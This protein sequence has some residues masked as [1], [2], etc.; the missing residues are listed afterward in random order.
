M[1][2]MTKTVSFLIFSLMVCSCNFINN[3]EK[4]IIDKKD[5]I[6][7]PIIVEKNEIMTIEKLD[8]E[9]PYEFDTIL[10]RG[11]KLHFEYFK[12][13]ENTEIEMALILMNNHIIIDTLNIMGY[14]APHKNLGYIGADFDEYFVFVNSFGSGN[15]HEMKLLKKNNAEKIVEGFF[16]DADEKNEILLYCK[17]YDSLMI[18]DIKKRTDKLIVDLNKSDYITSMVSQFSDD[19]KIKKVTNQFIEIEITQNSEKKIYKNYLR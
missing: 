14:G 6:S 10:K 2:T 15:P 12:E 16:V 8:K 13:K 17:G 18:Y 4:I 1:K 19:L 3:K 11:Y 5:S 7:E 9:Y